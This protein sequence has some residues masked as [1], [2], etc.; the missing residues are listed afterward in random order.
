MEKLAA[1]PWGT[2]TKPGPLARLLPVEQGGIGQLL[3]FFLRGLIVVA[4][5]YALI[6][7]ILAGYGYLSA[8]GDSKK[9]ADA[10]AKIYLSVIGLVVAAGSFVLAAI[11]GWLIFG[12]PLFI[13]NPKIPTP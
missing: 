3:S 6:N 9:V 10:A 1:D 5:I 4:G 13:I 11:F 2:I 7:F 8:G 12:D